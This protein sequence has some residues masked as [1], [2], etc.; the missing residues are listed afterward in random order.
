MFICF[1]RRPRMTETPVFRY[2][3]CSAMSRRTTSVHAHSSAYISHMLSYPTNCLLPT[4]SRIWHRCEIP[5]ASN[6]RSRPRQSSRRGREKLNHTNW[7]IIGA[8]SIKSTEHAALSILPD[9]LHITSKRNLLQPGSVQLSEAHRRQCCGLGHV[10]RKA[11]VS[12]LCALGCLR[13]LGF[14]GEANRVASY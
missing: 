10:C 11:H 1:K 8:T 3:R 4:R 9:G 12:P 5:H 2:R 14:G 7:G 13:F 6:Q